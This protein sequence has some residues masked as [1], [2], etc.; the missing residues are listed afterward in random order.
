MLCF[1]GAQESDKASKSTIARWIKQGITESYR[2]MNVSPPFVY[3]HSTRGLSEC[4]AERAGAL[5][6]QIWWPPDPAF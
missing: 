2:I 6:E 5:P 1:Y 4:G 3:A